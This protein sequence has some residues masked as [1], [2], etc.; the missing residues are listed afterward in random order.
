M[1][2]ARLRRSIG[3]SSAPSRSTSKA[4][5]RR[6]LEG[7]TDLDQARKTLDSNDITLKFL[8]NQTLP[9]LDLIGNYGAQG[10]GGTQF[11]RGGLGSSQ[12][13][14]IDARRLLATPG[15]R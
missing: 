7:R 2:R 1:A 13:L 4:A 5:V 11:I 12:V 8:H 10:L 14:E 3:P 15:A 6:A 9:A